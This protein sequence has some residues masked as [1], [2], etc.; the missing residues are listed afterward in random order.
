M[1]V[2]YNNQCSTLGTSINKVIPV[3]AIKTLK[4]QCQVMYSI[5]PTQTGTKH[6]SI[7][8]SATGQSSAKAE[9]M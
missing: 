8:L 4:Y 2:S 9:S 5:D 1:T 3:I 7:M 6:K